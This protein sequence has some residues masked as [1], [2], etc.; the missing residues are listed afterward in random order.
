MFLTCFDIVNAV[1]QLRYDL[2]DMHNGEDKY[3]VLHAWG[4]FLK[5]QHSLIPGCQKHNDARKY[6][7]IRTS[8]YFFEHG[9]VPAVKWPGCRTDS[10]GFAPVA[11]TSTTETYTN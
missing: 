4:G 1:D 5:T 9:D 6:I 10:I 8:Y 11:A 2:E 3:A 7:K